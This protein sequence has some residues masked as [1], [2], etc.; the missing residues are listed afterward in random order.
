MSQSARRPQE[1]DRLLKELL[2]LLP[3]I[4]EDYYWM[5]AIGWERQG[6]AT[7]R[8]HTSGVKDETRQIAHLSSYHKKLR[9]KV[10]AMDRLFAQMISKAYG[11][12]N[13]AAEIT[14]LIEDYSEH[15][16]RPEDTNAQVSGAE[17]KLA[18]E[19]QARRRQR[20]EGFGN[21]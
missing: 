12:Q 19:A 16:I 3:E 20:G 17:I 6:R 5:W 15:E 1:I 7:E 21:G 4:R 10:A 14:T 11:I 2:A 8:V 9:A 13:L 18:Q